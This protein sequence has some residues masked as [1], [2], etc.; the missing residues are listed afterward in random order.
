MVIRWKLIEY[1]I[2]LN[3]GKVKN[4]SAKGQKLYT[5]QDIKLTFYKV[6]VV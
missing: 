3:F 6:A 2:S 4:L 5:N 1:E